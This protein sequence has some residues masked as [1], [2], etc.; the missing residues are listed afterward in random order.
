M[1]AVATPW[2]LHRGVCR[3]S[4]RRVQAA[5]ATPAIFVSINAQT[6][7][8]FAPTRVPA[9]YWDGRHDNW[10]AG[11]RNELWPV[12]AAEG[13]WRGTR[14]LECVPLVGRLCAGVGLILLLG[15]CVDGFESR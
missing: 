12:N 1:S 6:L 10:H 5:R 3:T 2:C 9:I 13:G 4:S 15:R 14:G 11:P 8:T 7:N